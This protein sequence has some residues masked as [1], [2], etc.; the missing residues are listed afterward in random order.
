MNASI[1]TY[2]AR[3]IIPVST[4]PI[5]NGWLQTEGRHVIAMG[6]HSCPASQMD[7]G[8]VAILPQLVNS[9]THLE[10][11]HLD[12]PIGT[13][14]VS[15][16]D[17]I[18]LVIASR[19][20]SSSRDDSVRSGIEQSRR[21]GSSLIG[22][23]TTPPC[24]VGLDNVGLDNVGL[25]DDGLVDD[26][27]RDGDPVLAGFAEVLGLSAAR[28]T[29]RMQ[30]ALAHMALNPDCGLSPHSPYSTTRETILAC[31][32]HSQAT[33]CSLAMHVAESPAERELLEHATGPLQESLERLGVLGEGLFP[34]A[35]MP[36]KW[37]I[38]ALSGSTRALLIH[39]NDLR[40]AEIAMIAAHPHLSVVYCPRTH[41][42]F[43]YDKHPVAEMIRG[44]VRVAIGTDSLASNPDL[45]VW[46]EV[47][48]LLAHRQD[49]DPTEVLRMATIHGA[50]A[51]G[52]PKLG[53]IEVGC[54]CRLGYVKTRAT[55]IAG[56]H[57][58]FAEQRFQ[59]LPGI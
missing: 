41:A 22:E 25:D 38:E 19:H 26:R 48:Y 30:A 49:L 40:A 37:L 2:R 8:D 53:R 45:S 3:W 11:S 34:W 56:L 59:A 33:R 36:F 13:P 17:W 39:G 32:K 47:Q 18:G 28:S 46:G 50:D 55:A 12:E 24:N 9:H 16:A 14:G 21:W 1:R 31:V 5:H 10:F 4:P 58:D 51:L 23:I 29:E 57:R 43:G 27:S 52:Y 20:Q 15:L 7:L 42:F 44:G 35:A 54:E 6:D